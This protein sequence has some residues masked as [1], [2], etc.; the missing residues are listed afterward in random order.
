MRWRTIC[1]ACSVPGDQRTTPPCRTYCPLSRPRIVSSGIARSTF[2]P[3]SELNMVLLRLAIHYDVDQNNVPGS[4]KVRG[5]GLR[6]KNSL[7][8][9]VS[10]IPHHGAMNRFYDAAAS[11]DRDVES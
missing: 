8:A 1:P 6:F 4:N 2:R 5:L 10:L 3:N 11:S 9:R 7:F